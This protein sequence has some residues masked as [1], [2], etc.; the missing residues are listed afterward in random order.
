MFQFFH[1]FFDP[2]P[3]TPGVIESA[4]IRAAVERVVDGVDP[5]L[6]AVPHYQRTLWQ[7]VERAVTY[8][9]ESVKG[10]P[11]AIP[12]DR[13]RSQVD[14]R[15]R[16]LFLG[17]DHVLETLSSS[18]DVRGYLEQSAGPPPP[19]L[20]VALRV[21]RTERT[22]LGMSL[23]DDRL[24]RDVPQT[25]VSFHNHRVAFPAADESETRRQVQSR[26]FDYLIE[27]ARHRLTATRARRIQ[28][29]QQLQQGHAK[30]AAA[31]RL[32]WGDRGLARTPGPAVEDPV[33][34]QRLREIEGEL[35]Q[36][37]ADSATFSEQL[38][39]VAKMVG[40]PRK[41]LRLDRVSLT[42]DALNIKVPKQARKAADTLTFNEMRI[43][44]DRSITLEMIRFPSNQ[45]L[46]QPDFVTGFQR[47]SHQSCC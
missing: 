37:R 21:E 6:R 2:K 1:S 29:E 17:P 46:E 28:L 16:A 43:G 20:F 19:E 14:P 12:F 36:L 3:P 8:L 15:L 40:E 9:S 24:M 32:G 45:L 5:R 10:M 26:A 11:P 31:A 47:L 30:A 23:V 35:G 39:F 7:P 4:A 34:G 18:P 33:D 13:H 44:A 38:A 42:L 27:V 25:T 22:I 41:H